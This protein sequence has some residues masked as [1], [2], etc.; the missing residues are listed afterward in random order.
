MSRRSV[1]VAILGLTA[2]AFAPAKASLLPTGGGPKC[3]AEQPPAGSTIVPDDGV[4]KVA[5]LNVLHGLIEEPPAYPTSSTLNVRTSLAASEIAQ[6]GVDIVGMEEVSVIQ[7]S[8]LDPNHPPEVAKAFAQRVAKDTGTTWYWCWFLAN[9]HFPVEP[10][11]QPGG[12][13]PI[14]DTEATLVS[15]FTGAPYQSFKEGLAIISRYPITDSE[16]LHLPGRIPVEAAL[17]PFGSDGITDPQY[18]VDNIGDVP[19]CIETVLFETRAALWARMDTPLGAIDLTTTHLAH[20]ITAGSDLSSLQQAAV[21]LAFSDARSQAA[22]APAQRFFTCDCNSQPEDDVPVIGYI[23][24]QGWVNTLPGGCSTNGICTGGPDQIVTPTPTKVMDER[25]DYVFARAGQ[26]T[27]DPGLFV[28]T[29]LAPGAV[30]DGLTNP[31]NGYLWP[32]DHF[33]VEAT[34]C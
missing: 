8:T 25:I 22:G 12:G 13:G 14:S 21:A 6:A 3:A 33:G 24:S 17:C 1:I 27:K 7:G 23:E 32:S 11:L 20:G 4:I 18:V 30:I 28:N 19:S 2:V 31:T 26:C 34:I 9:P 10:D 16:G 15:Q 5:N 29:P